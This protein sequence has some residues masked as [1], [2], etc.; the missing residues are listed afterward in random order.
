MPTYETEI[1]V[2][3][4]TM[5]DRH[6]QGAAKAAVI[7]LNQMIDGGDLNGRD[8]WA[9]VVRMIHQRQGAGARSKHRSTATL[10]SSRRVA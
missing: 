9:C 3:A 7:H 8:R 4:G 5:I 10:P 2:L 1:E 6:G